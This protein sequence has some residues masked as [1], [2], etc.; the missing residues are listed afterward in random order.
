L[1]VALIDAL[2]SAVLVAVALASA[3]GPAT[4]FPPLVPA[5]PDATRLSGILHW[6]AICEAPG[7]VA[8]ALTP[9]LSAAAGCGKA[10][11]PI[12]V[13]SILAVAV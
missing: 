6:L 10:A 12:P 8:P 5:I 4:V 11:I 3:F 2:R 1:V 9:K 13:V 7:A